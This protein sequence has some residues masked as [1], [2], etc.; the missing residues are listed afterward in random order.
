MKNPFPKRCENGHWAN[1]KN[2]SADH[3]ECDACCLDKAVE[4]ANREIEE[5]RLPPIPYQSFE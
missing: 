2:F 3:N 4:K 1:R 5:E